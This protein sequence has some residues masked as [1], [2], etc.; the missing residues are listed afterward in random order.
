MGSVSGFITKFHIW[1]RPNSLAANPITSDGSKY[2]GD[3]TEDEA[4]LWFDEAMIFA[5]AGSGGAGSSAVKF[6]KARQHMKPSGGSGGDGGSV[7]FTVDTSCNTLL[8]FRGRSS[9][10][11]ENGRDG[12]QEYANGLKG[13]DCFVAVPKGTVVINN[14][15]N[16]VIGELTQDGD[17]LV[18]ANGGQGGCGNAAIQAK[19]SS[20]KGTS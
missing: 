20:T 3:I 14:S 9:Y 5:R 18:V 6:G 13:T 12:E 7:V 19:G 16:V 15:T 8:A 10:R 1:K 11:A 2:R 17:Q 4:F